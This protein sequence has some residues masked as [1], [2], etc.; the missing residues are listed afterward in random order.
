MKISCEKYFSSAF[1]PVELC[2]DADIRCE[3]PNGIPVSGGSKRATATF[4]G[5]HIFHRTCSFNK[6]IVIEATLHNRLVAAPIFSTD[7]R[8][9]EVLNALH[10]WRTDTVGLEPQDSR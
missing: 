3:K 8:R 6:S 2:T 7:D 10:G 4:K 5:F 9:N 1:R